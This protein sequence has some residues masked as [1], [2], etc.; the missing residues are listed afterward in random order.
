MYMYT[1]I[2]VYAYIHTYVRTYIHTCIH[3]Y[4]HTYVHTYVHTCIL[5][6]SV[7]TT[8]SLFADALQA[9]AFVSF[10]PTHPGLAGDE[11]TRPGPKGPRTWNGTSSV[12]RNAMEAQGAKL[13]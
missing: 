10:S 8:L 6:P 12:R 2:C 13:G 11:V 1:Q 4:I 3:A 5:I 9:G 7:F